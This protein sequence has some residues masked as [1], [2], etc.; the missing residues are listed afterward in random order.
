MPYSTQKNNYLL[1]I[2]KDQIW[3]PNLSFDYLIS[4]DRIKENSM[5]EVIMFYKHKNTWKI[6]K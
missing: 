6:K 5:N 4:A 1:S 3:I 2:K